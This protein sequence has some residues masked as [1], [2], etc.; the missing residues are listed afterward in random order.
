MGVGTIATAIGENAGTV[1]EV[2]EP[3]LIQEGLLMRTPRGRQATEAAYRHLGR[4]P[5]AATGGLFGE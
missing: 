5:L 4:L 2:Y 1:E 3:Y